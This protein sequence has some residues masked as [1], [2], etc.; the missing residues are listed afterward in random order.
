MQR[1]MNAHPKGILRYNLW[2]L[3]K[4][5]VLC[6]LDLYNV[7]V[8]IILFKN[9]GQGYDSLVESLGKDVLPIEYG[10]KNGPLEE[11]IG[12]YV[13]LLYVV[14]SFLIQQLGRCSTLQCWYLVLIS[15]LLHRSHFSLTEGKCKLSKGVIHKLY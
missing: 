6:S 15:L 2:I 12:T 13:Y 10:G 11:H 9:K 14:F 7:H 3:N 5:Q 8:V 4:I 1:R